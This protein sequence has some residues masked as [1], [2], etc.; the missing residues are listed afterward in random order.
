MMYNQMVIVARPQSQII[1]GDTV[2]ENL[3]EALDNKNPFVR[4]F[5]VAIFG[6]MAEGT[7]LSY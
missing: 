4:D 7:L 6:D 3:T 1:Y 2:I 5:A